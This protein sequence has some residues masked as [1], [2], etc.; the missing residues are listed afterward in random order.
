M[1]S[2]SIYYVF[3]GSFNQF[4]CNFN[5]FSKNWQ[6][7]FSLKQVHFEKKGYDVKIDITNKN[8]SRESNFITDEVILQKSD[9]SKIF[10]I[11]YTVTI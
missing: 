2:S 11:G 5:G 10:M 3:K 4:N 6:L 9:S 7:K 8:V 1:G